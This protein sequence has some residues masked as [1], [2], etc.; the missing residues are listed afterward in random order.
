MTVQSHDFERCA[1]TAHFQ[2]IQ[3]T[4]RFP[5]GFPLL[6]L[7]DVDSQIQT[8]SS[9]LA[10][11]KKANEWWM[12]S[13]MTYS[14]WRSPFD[15]ISSTPFPHLSLSLSLIHPHSLHA[16]A[17]VCIYSSSSCTGVT[18]RSNGVS[19]RLGSKAVFIHSIEFSFLV[20]PT[21]HGE[22][23]VHL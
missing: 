1:S 14:A 18:P 13:K 2:V 6:L 19:T 17:E 12:D 15:S 5:P 9:V 23:A 10:M 22:S 21:T 16:H 11:C 7:F 8:L 20:D 4:S 3:W